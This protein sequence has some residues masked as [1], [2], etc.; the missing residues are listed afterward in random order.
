MSVHH[1]IIVAPLFTEMTSE[2]RE[3]DKYVF[4]VALNSDKG[5]IKRAIEAIFSV[6]VES[7]NT[8]IVKGKKKRVGRFVGY[9]SDRKK[10]VIKLKDGETIDRFGDV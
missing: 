1:S 4:E 5:Q 6:H 8:M 2:L 7:V 9:K 10:A 3:Q